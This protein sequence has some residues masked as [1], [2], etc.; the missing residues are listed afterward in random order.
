[1]RSII[2]HGLHSC[3]WC[4]TA[5]PTHHIVM[6]DTR[7]HYDALWHTHHRQSKENYFYALL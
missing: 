3:K 6:H 1:M 4:V 7:L 5:Q 2:I